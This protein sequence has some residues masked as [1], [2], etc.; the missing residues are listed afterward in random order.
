MRTI[1]ISVL[2]ATAL[3]TYRS[4][5]VAAPDQTTQYPG[6][7]TEARVWIQNRPD[8]GE[9]IPMMLESTARDLPPLR[10]QVVNADPQHA[11]TNPVIVRMAPRTWEYKTVYVGDNLDPAPML[12]KEG[13]SGWETAGVTWRQTNLTAWLLKR[14]R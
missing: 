7:M 14:P 10:V 8:R 3:V 5:M 9:A 2:A 13:A 12:S 4:E 1:V 11:L 6:Q